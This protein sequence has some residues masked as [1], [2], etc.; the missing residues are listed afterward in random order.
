MISEPELIGADGGSAGPPQ[1]PGARREPDLIDFDPDAGFVLDPEPAPARVRWLWAL[2]G[3]VVASAVW[4]GGISVY[5][6]GD[7]DP[8]GYRSTGNLCLEAPMKGLTAILGEAVDN[9]PRS[10][11]H[12]ARDTAT[13]WY[14]FPAIVTS[15]DFDGPSL[16]LM[17]TLHKKTDPGPEFE[18]A[19][20]T[21]MALD[22]DS[23]L[24]ER[25]DG[26]GERTLGHSWGDGGGKLRVLDG[27]AVFELELHQGGLMSSRAR[28][29]PADLTGVREPLLADLRSLMTRLK[30]DD[31]TD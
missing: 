5:D 4:A 13:C 17:Y 11:K 29:K 19:V 23:A 8:G 26:L 2:G 21:E 28:G 22:G 6:A 16:S 27:Q 30:G 7:P 14:S 1:L 18:A 20:L 9:Q 24:L 15:P 12:E 31:R 25:I 10:R 3:A